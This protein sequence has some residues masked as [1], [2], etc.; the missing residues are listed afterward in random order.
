MSDST[1]KTW[2]I[3]GASS[4]FGEA[5]ADYVLEKGDRV[6][7]TFRKPE[8]ADEFTKKAEG[9]TFGLV[10]DVTDEATVKTA[11]ADAIAKHDGERAAAAMR[12]HIDS[13]KGRLMQIQDATRRHRPPPIR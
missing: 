2:F 11:I 13:L 3:T 5:L 9:R 10:C 12:E 4:G 7:A 8:Q 1:A 6:A